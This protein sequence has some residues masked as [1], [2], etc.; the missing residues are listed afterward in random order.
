M[1]SSDVLHTPEFILLFLYYFYILIYILYIYLNINLH[2]IY[3]PEFIEFSDFISTCISMKI[4][5]IS[6][7]IFEV[8]MEWT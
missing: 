3:T 8:V 1:R 5:I 4:N 7:S 6:A 2:Y